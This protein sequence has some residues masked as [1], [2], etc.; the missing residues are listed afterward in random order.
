MGNFI[1]TRDVGAA[2]AAILT[3]NSETFKKFIAAGK[4]EIH[5]PESTSFQEQIAKL[6]KAVGYDIKI[7]TVPGSA[8]VGALMGFGMSKLFANSFLDT[9]EICDSKRTPYQP[10]VQKTSELLLSIYKPK[11]TVDDW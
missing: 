8:W 1:D 3:S 9:V 5:G 7:N 11:Y 2:A 6:S 4:I 10:M